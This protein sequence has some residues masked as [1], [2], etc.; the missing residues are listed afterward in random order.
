[1]VRVNLSGKISQITLH[2]ELSFI[3]GEVYE[4]VKVKTKGKDQGVVL[5]TGTFL[6]IETNE[7][8]DATIDFSEKELEKH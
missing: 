8:L 2:G 5:V 4:V 1:M 6:V 7:R 3:E